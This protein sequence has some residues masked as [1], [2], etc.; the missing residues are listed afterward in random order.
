MSSEGG[1]HRPGHRGAE[2]TPGSTRLGSGAALSLEDEPRA[3][4]DGLTPTTGG[5]LSA[6]VRR[7]LKEGEI[8]NTAHRLRARR[9]VRGVPADRVDYVQQLATKRA[10]VV[11]AT[12]HIPALELIYTRPV[13]P[14]EPIV[15][16]RGR[17]KL[18]VV[19]GREHRPLRPHAETTRSS[20]SRL[21]AC[22]RR[23]W[24]R[25]PARVRA[26]IADPPDA[27]RRCSCPYDPLRRR[28]APRARSAR[29]P[30]AREPRAHGRARGGRTRGRRRCVTFVLQR[31]R[32]PSRDELSEAGK[33]PARRCCPRVVGVAVN[34]HD[35][36]APQILGPET[37]VLD[38][39]RSP[40]TA[41]ARR[42]HLASFGSF[43]QAH[44]EQAA[45]VHA[46]VVARD[47]ARSS[48]ATRPPRRAGTAGAARPRCSTSTAARARSRWRWRTP[49]NERDDGRVVRAGD[50]ERA[51]RGRGAGAL[52][53]GGP[54]RR[55]R[56]G[57]RPARRSRTSSSTPW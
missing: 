53:P 34:F 28:R 10:R 15:G 49:S 29:G 12:S 22:S 36:D 35:A 33:R 13:E 40:R 21:A 14:A 38:G 50:A 37:L 44:R 32:A 55:R 30:L 26:L 52:Q 6:S 23:R 7:T 45:R 24:R 18:I 3:G 54:H 56:R 5:V 20:T 39:V 19:P 48:S 47:R 43:V 46:L 9:R 2:V 31:D 57:G 42:Y 16:Y 1:T 51:H 25:S 4:G 41:S 11:T 27:A 17:A 8:P